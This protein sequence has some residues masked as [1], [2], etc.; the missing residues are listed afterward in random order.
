MSTKRKIRPA[1][2]KDMFTARKLETQGVSHNDDSI[3]IEP[4][5]VVLK[6]GHTTVRIPMS[7]FKMFAEWFLEEQEVDGL[8]SEPSLDTSSK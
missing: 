2:C 3:H 8:P 4:N 1:D 6:M 5:S 7:R